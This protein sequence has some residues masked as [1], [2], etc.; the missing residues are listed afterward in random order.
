M[1]FR[2]ILVPLL[3]CAAAAPLAR[4]RADLSV[5]PLAGRPGAPNTLYLD[6]HGE[7]TG[8]NWAGIVR[9]APAYDV[10]GDPSSFSA[11]EL[12]NI[13]SIDAVVAGAFSPFNVNVTTIDPGGWDAPGGTTRRLRACIGGT[14]AW[15]GPA[16]ANFGGIAYL[17]GFVS[18]SVPNTVFV[19]S[20][21]L[22]N[23]TEYVADD[24][25]HEAGHGAG[26]Q[27]QSVWVNGVKT[28]EYNPGDGT[29]GPWMGVPFGEQ[30]RWWTG[31]NSAGVMQDDVQFLTFNLGAVPTP[32]PSAAAALFALIALRRTR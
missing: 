1:T 13:A 19:F 28:A 27:H 31:L 22:G 11:V 24:A 25:V 10:D 29:Y 17:G 8:I 5:P 2:L 12:T 26:L 15:L 23:V 18:V 30:G 21:S 4:A 32:E 9:P 20:A 7:P 3:L 16:A 14:N 6:F